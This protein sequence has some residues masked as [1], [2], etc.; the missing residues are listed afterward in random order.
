MP[1]GISDSGKYRMTEC[2]ADRSADFFSKT[3]EMVPNALDIPM[4][5]S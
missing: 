4:Y 3:S 1:G 5:E 2:S